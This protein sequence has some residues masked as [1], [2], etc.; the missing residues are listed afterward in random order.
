M[1]LSQGQA[2]KKNEE[3]NYEV[4]AGLATTIAAMPLW[5]W[6]IEHVSGRCRPVYVRNRFS[7]KKYVRHFALRCV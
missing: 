7:Q 4:E 2:T 3:S 6:M 1:H 5:V